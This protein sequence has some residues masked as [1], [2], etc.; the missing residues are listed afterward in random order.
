MLSSPPQAYKKSLGGSAA[1]E[2]DDGD[3]GG[4]MAKWFDLNTK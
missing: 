2:T 3:L 1:P 4:V